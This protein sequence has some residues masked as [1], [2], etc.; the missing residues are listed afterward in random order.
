MM[1]RLEGIPTAYLQLC[2]CGFQF[3][4]CRPLDLVA[5]P[6]T[7]RC[8][9]DTGWSS[10]EPWHRLRM[11]KKSL[12]FSEIFIAGLLYLCF[13][14]V[15]NLGAYS[16]PSETGLLIPS[17]LGHCSVRVGSTI[18][19]FIQNRVGTFLSF[20]AKALSVRPGDDGVSVSVPVRVCNA[21]RPA[22]WNVSWLLSKPNVS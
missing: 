22:L 8:S 9:D 11:L 1:T 18:K 20:Q 3:W 13:E 21:L 16:I 7:N 4:T 5:Q 14:H 10:C 15:D 19:K 6:Q 2:Q 12:I 17:V